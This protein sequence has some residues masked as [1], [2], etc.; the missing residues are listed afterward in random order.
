MNIISISLDAS[1]Y[2]NNSGI[3]KDWPPEHKNG[4]N[5]ATKNHYKLIKIYVIVAYHFL[6]VYNVHL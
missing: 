2:N 6:D 3:K 4:Y 1:H 5:T